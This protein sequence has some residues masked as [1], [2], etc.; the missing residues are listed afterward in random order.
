MGPAKAKTL[1]ITKLEEV[2]VKKR[3]WKQVFYLVSQEKQSDS[4]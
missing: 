1:W 2:L 3:G 4:N